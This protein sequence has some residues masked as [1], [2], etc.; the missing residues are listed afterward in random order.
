MT[1][2]LTPFFSPRGVALVG[3][4]SNPDKISYNVLRNLAH[5]GYQGAVYPVNPRYTEIEGMVCYRDVTT[6]PDPV[7]LAVIVLPTEYIPEV[8]KACGHRG[9]KAVTIVSSGFKE[10]GQTGEAIEAECLEIARQYGMRL[11]GPN[12]VGTID[13]TSGLNTTFIEGVPDRGCIGFISQS[14][15]VCGAIIN[16]YSD[17]RI[18]FSRCVSL[19]NEAD[20]TETDMIEFMAKD[21]DTRVIAAYVEGISDG[22]RF[23]DVVER[24]S[25]EKP[26]VVLKAGRT[27]VG[28]QAG[29]TTGRPAGHRWRFRTAPFITDAPGQG[30]GSPPARRLQNT[31]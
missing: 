11:I 13:L 4:S 16:C 30:T 7:D 8:L 3:A 22:R 5:S 12:C 15:G 6:V 20:V 9:I 1:S 17:Q 10:A 26:V 28:E 29:H 19:G 18:G 14:G 27:R 25:P 23:T 31:L 24:V 2:D 21:P